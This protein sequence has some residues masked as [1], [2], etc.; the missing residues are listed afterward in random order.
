[1]PFHWLRRS[2]VLPALMAALVMMSG[3]S[4]SGDDDDDDATVTPTVAPTANISVDPGSYDFGPVLIGKSESTTFTVSN[5]GEAVLKLTKYQVSGST[6][7]KV[8]GSA[9]ELEKGASGTFSVTFTP[10]VVGKIT[11]TLALLSNDPDAPS[12]EISLTG[13]GDSPDA[14]DDGYTVA[15][16][17][18]NDKDDAINPGEAEL[19]DG[20]DNNCEDGE[21]DAIDAPT[22]YVDSDGDGYGD[23]TNRKKEVACEAPGRT[24][25]A[26]NNLDCDDTLPEISPDAEE[27]C[28]EIDNNCD[29]QVDEGFDS[30]D[31]NDEV[32]DC[33]DADGDGFS[34]D[35]G[36]CDDTNAQVFPGAVEIFNDLDDNCD[37]QIDEDTP[38]TVTVLTPSNNAVLT[39]GP[40]QVSVN[41]VDQQSGDAD[42]RVSLRS[43]LAPTGRVQEDACAG[44]VPVNG[45]V[46]CELNL[47]YGKQDIVIEATDGAGEG[48]TTTVRSPVVVDNPPSASFASPSD[49]SSV[50]YGEDLAINVTALDDNESLTTDNLEFSSDVEGVLTPVRLTASPTTPG[51]F[52]GALRLNKVGAHVLTMKVTDS[53]GI[54]TRTSV[55]VVV[56]GPDCST[57]NVRALWRMNEGSGKQIIDEISDLSGTLS[58]VTFTSSSGSFNSAFAN[59]I[60]FAGEGSTVEVADA[61]DRLSLPNFTIDFWFKG[62]GQGTRALGRQALLYKNGDAGTSDRPNYY[63]SVGNTGLLEVKL[64]VDGPNT[65]LTATAAE[66]SVLLANTWYHIATTFDGR[67]L[68]AFI[69]GKQVASIDSPLPGASARVANT[70]FYLGINKNALTPPGSPVLSGVLDEVQLMDCAMIPDDIKA[71]YDTKAPHVLPTP[72]PVP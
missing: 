66:D 26:D 65:P 1:M 54:F 41:V 62:A 70:P 15:E 11:A 37:G 5:E 71:Y 32:A 19:C 38:P 59:A 51:T 33:F 36:D 47:A 14:D 45:L 10:N 29:T 3:C 55:G 58:A 13:Q 53:L 39:P 68:K 49:G 23:P 64:T 20:I 28:D 43:S 61:E 24:G 35:E 60:S 48:L 2:S 42:L 4:A 9:L 18:C 21:D 17:D 56:V 44:L 7:F 25:W 6:N 8:S 67:S 72:E 16:G 30:P 12:L 34:G 40:V 52:T 22:W 57:A 46:S 63:V 50:N 27:L 69:N 31:D